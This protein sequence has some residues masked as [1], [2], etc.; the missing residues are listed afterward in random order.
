[1]LQGQ[2]QNWV[3]TVKKLRHELADLQ[4][5]KPSVGKESV[6][7]TDDTLRLERYVTRAIQ[8]HTREAEFSRGTRRASRPGPPPPPVAT[9]QIFEVAVAPERRGRAASRPT[10]ARTSDSDESDAELGP[11]LAPSELGKGSRER[12]SREMEV[13]GHD[14]YSYLRPVEAYGSDATDTAKASSSRSKSSHS[15]ERQRQAGDMVREEHIQLRPA[16]ER[17]KRGG[18]SAG[19]G[20][21]SRSVNNAHA[22]ADPVEEYSA[23][24][25][26]G[27]HSGEERVRRRR[28]RPRPQPPA[29]E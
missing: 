9:D 6:T 7:I 2:L 22:H 20:S 29:R 4:R 5:R 15:Q 19:S 3:S 1:M 26:P 10:P 11:P 18:S 17:V 16:E 23:R 28:R 21:K 12:P 25:T 8:S 13:P 14:S 24:S 27:S